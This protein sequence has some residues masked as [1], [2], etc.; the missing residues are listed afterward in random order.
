MAIST[1][2]QIAAVFGALSL[3]VGVVAGF[4]GYQ[5]TGY[6]DS[7]G[8]ATDCYGRTGG[9]VRVGVTSSDEKCHTEFAHDL[10][11][12]ALAIQPCIKVDVPQPS[13]AAFISF[14]YN[15]GVSNFCHSTLVKKLNAGD[16]A[17]A[18]NE[19]PRWNKAGGRVINGLTKRRA[20]ERAL[21]LQGVTP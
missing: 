21:C 2:K 14:S 20:Q 7:V 11:D 1:P 12:H 3:A 4:E 16:L 5:P 9:D 10:Y 17:G 6:H 15:V 18:C 19:L 13:M 8:V